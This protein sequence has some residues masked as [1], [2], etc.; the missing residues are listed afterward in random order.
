MSSF[1]ENDELMEWWNGVVGTLAEVLFF[2]VN[3]F[4]YL[5]ECTSVVLCVYFL[6]LIQSSGFFVCSVV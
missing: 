1:Q 2:F 5:M 4:L 6:H 3:V